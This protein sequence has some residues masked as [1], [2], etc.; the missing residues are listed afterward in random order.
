MVYSVHDMD[1]K[2]EWNCERL[3][4]YLTTW[5]GYQKYMKENPESQL[6]ENLHK[7]YATGCFKKNRSP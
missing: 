3:K 1:I 2:A 7:K 4:N 6:L 5:S